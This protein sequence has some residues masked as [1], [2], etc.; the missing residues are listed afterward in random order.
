MRLLYCHDN[1]YNVHPDGDLYSE[2]QFSYEYWHPFLQAFNH[3]EIAGRYRTNGS[4]INFN[5]LNRSTGPGVSFNLLPNINGPVHL[6]K[7]YISVFKALKAAIE[8]ADAV[9]VRA[10]SD[11]GWTA[12]NIA[13]AMRKPVGYEL[14]ACAWDST[15]NHKHKAG[16]LYAL[17]RFL[18]NRIMA[19]GA[20]YTVSVS[21]DFL[22]RRYPIGGKHIIASNVRLGAPDYDAL[23][24]RLQKI[25]GHRGPYT[26]G[27]IGALNNN[28]K[29]VDYALK[30]LRTLNA[31]DPGQFRFRHIGQGSPR[32][33]IDK[34]RT[35]G[36]EH[37]VS[38]EGPRPSG[39]P[40]LSFLDEID[41]YIQP[42]LQEGVPRSVLEA[43][44]RGCPVIASTAGGIPEILAAQ[45][46]H[47]PRD[48]GA[49]A[50]L[51]RNMQK[52]NPRQATAARRNFETAKG[53]T[54]DVLMTR[55]IAFWR[56]FADLARAHHE[57]KANTVFARTGDSLIVDT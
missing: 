15:W 13:K 29:G 1:F 12:Y 35:L 52:D 7:N 14:S 4:D 38:F 28:L 48:D 9:V 3:I 55:R 16:K 26:I 46:L 18:F 19:K 37:L 21:H 39:T 10:V 23:D 36:I 57:Q 5:T 51:I 31:Q 11:I 43:M 6:C 41:L 30:A 49:L 34:A 56:G 53:F 44:S 42:S 32:E 54:H 40:V 25:Q 20:D 50:R 45:D 22:P 8:R 24:R 27:L 47:K 33:Y 17:P 2:G